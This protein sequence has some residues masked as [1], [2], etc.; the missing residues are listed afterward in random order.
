MRLLLKFIVTPGGKLLAVA[1]KV[2]VQL[3][4]VNWYVTSDIAAVWLIC[5]CGP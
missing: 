1:D 2:P 5:V 4:D 3:L